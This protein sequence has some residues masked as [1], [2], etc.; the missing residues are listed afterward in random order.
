MQTRT[1]SVVAI[2]FVVTVG[3]A[4]CSTDESS[5]GMG[6]EPATN[7][8]PSLTT[9]VEGSSNFEVTDVS[10]DQGSIS[11]AIEYT[12]TCDLVQADLRFTY[13]GRY[14]SNR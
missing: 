14:S 9:G 7:A 12:G 4:S 3:S 6:E 10:W 1:G 5:I 2:L 11:A 8:D 13:Q